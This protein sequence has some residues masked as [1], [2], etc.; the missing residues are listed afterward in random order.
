MWMVVNFLKKKLNLRRVHRQVRVDQF[1]P[2]GETVSAVNFVSGRTR[3]QW[4]LSLGVQ[5]YLLVTLIAVEDADFFVVARKTD[6]PVLGISVPTASFFVFAALLC[7]ALY[8]SLH[9]H[10]Q[11]LWAGFAKLTAQ[12]QE[13]IEQVEPWIVV[14]MLKISFGSE[15]VKSR[16]MSSVVQLF[17]VCGIWLFSPSLLTAFW[18]KYMTSHN[19][20]NS[21]L[22]GLLVA[23][24][25]TVA[26]ASWRSFRRLKREEQE[27]VGLVVSTGFFVLLMCL[28]SSISWGRTSH[29]ITVAWSED[30]PS[31]TI[32]SLT[33]YGSPPDDHIQAE[34][35]L[36]AYEQQSELKKFVADNIPFVA[37]FYGLAPIDLRGVEL[38]ERPMNWLPSS[39][40]RRSSSEEICGSLGYDAGRCDLID[41]LGGE[42]SDQQVSDRMD[43]CSDNNIEV[44]CLESFEW[45][46]DWARSTW[47]GMRARARVALTHLD[48]RNADLRGA[49]LSGAFLVGAD[50]TGA[51]LDFA[52]LNGADFEGVKLKDAVLSGVSAWRS[53]FQWV[54]GWGSDWIYSVLYGAD[55]GSARLR[56]VNFF[57]ADLW[58]V[59]ITDAD[60]WGAHFQETTLR[61]VDFSRSRFWGGTWQGASVEGVRLFGTDLSYVSGLTQMML[62]STIGDGSTVLT[63][64]DQWDPRPNHRVADCWR[65]VPYSVAQVPMSTGIVRFGYVA[66]VDWICSESEQVWNEAT[67][68]FAEQL[69]DRVIPGGV[70]VRIYGDDQLRPFGPTYWQREHR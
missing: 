7:F 53:N 3:S 65:D 21:L 8:L 31:I 48:L 43:W 18:W 36:A 69:I 27:P 16:H 52:V 50:L 11:R 29:S 19:T 70:E 9:I 56:G 54:D 2:V 15:E 39:I 60:L 30:G 40:A 67:R 63:K 28:T 4:Y 58:H 10:M 41:W 20:P 26:L 37:R 68:P 47:S 23:L 46:D 62:N 17:A 14:D 66:P 59:E 44:F 64:R 25:V 61:S 5:V 45:Q 51:R 57:R 1:L 34:G 6:L 38:V 12:N 32:P 35:L 22:L 55:L 42:L 49:D 33:I 13:L 24:S